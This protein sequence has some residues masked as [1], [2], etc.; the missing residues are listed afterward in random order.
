MRLPPEIEYLGHTTL[1]N[2]DFIWITNKNTISTWDLS[3]I[4]TVG[5][6]S[7]ICVGI[8]CEWNYRN[9]RAEVTR[10]LHSLFPIHKLAVTY[11]S[12]TNIFT[13]ESF[14]LLLKNLME[15]DSLSFCG[16][17]ESIDCSRI[18]NLEVSITNIFELRQAA[19][20]DNLDFGA[21]WKF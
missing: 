12:K 2:E 15:L 17:R 9:G 21:T 10:T 13:P 19:L 14:P 7:P 6:E 1:K 11:L 5:Y 20:R 3:F 16:R 4:A 18:E 8:D